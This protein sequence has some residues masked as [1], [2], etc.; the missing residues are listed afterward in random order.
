M[1]VRAPLL[2]ALVVVGFLLVATATVDRPTRAGAES[3][4]DQLVELIETRRTEIAELDEEV[5]SLRESV[6]EAQEGVAEAGNLDPEEVEEV[7]RA[8]GLTPLEGPGL[9]VTVDD[10]DPSLTQ[11]ERVVPF[12]V[13][14]RDLQALTNALWAA[15]AE[16]IAVN[17]ERLVATT[18]IRNGGDTITVNFRPIAPPYEVTA[19]GADPDQLIRSEI[20]GQLERWSERYGVGFAVEASD[21]VEVQAYAGGSRL[22]FARPLEPSPGM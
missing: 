16:A 19:V 4:R 2:A 13:I 20:V 17:G 18:A 12:Q 7:R 1:R 8:A 15:G 6:A 5:A 3:R 10:P 21:E 9:V 11:D 22:R 14:D